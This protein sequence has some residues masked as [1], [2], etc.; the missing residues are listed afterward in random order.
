MKADAPITEEEL[1]EAIGPYWGRRLMA[2]SDLDKLVFLEL[3][4]Y[5]GASNLDAMVA[6]DPQYN[7]TQTTPE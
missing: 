7:I 1:T 6:M 2:Y 4:L 5:H 3:V